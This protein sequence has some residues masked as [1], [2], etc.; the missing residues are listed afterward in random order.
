MGLDR[1]R[2]SPPSCWCLKPTGGWAGGA[3]PRPSPRTESRP[4]LRRLSERCV[5][6]GEALSALL[7][8]GFVGPLP[9]FP[10]KERT[11]PSGMFGEEGG[12]KGGSRATLHEVPDATFCL[13]GDWLGLG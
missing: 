8:Q 5:Q 4:S 12:G 10:H 11:Q 13:P 3:H 6:D 7:G 1:P 9:L 2:S